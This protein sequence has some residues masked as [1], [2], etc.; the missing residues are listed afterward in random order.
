MDC[1]F[2]LSNGVDDKEDID[3]ENGA[4]TGGDT[5]G[6]STVTDGDI[7]GGT[8]LRSGTNNGGVIG[9]VLGGE[10]MVGGGRFVMFVTVEGVGK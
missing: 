8:I 1:N 4:I 6:G 3:T 9:S 2:L 7:L 10:E 5:L